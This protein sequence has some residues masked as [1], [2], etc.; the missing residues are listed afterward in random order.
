LK[1]P[2]DASG[3][4]FNPSLLIR[5]FVSTYAIRVDEIRSKAR[6]F[7]LSVSRTD[8]VTYLFALSPNVTEPH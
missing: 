5:G 1:S 8:A 4:S 7:R 2:S 6:S 3:T